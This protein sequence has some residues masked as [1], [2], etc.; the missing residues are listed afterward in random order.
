MVGAVTV[1]V[2]EWGRRL[3]DALRTALESGDLGTARRLALEGDGQ[4]RSLA[5]SRAGGRYGRRRP[6]RALAGTSPIGAAP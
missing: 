1:P 2:K 6:L 4:A 5:K 3:S